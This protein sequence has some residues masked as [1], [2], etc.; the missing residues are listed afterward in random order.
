MRRGSEGEYGAAPE[1]KGGRKLE[2]LEKTLRAAASFG[3]NSHVRKLE[4]EPDGNR[5]T[6]SLVG[7]GRSSS[8]TSAAPRGTSAA[9]TE[10]R[11]TP[12]VC[13]LLLFASLRIGHLTFRVPQ[14]LTSRRDSNGR[15]AAR[16]TSAS[17]TEH[18]DRS[19][20]VALLYTSP[21][22]RITGQA[23]ECQFL[24]NGRAA[25]GNPAVLRSPRFNRLRRNQYLDG[26]MRPEKLDRRMSK[27]I[28]LMTMLILPK[29]E[30]HTISMQIDLKQVFQKCSFYREQPVLPDANY[31]AARWRTAWP[32]RRLSEKIWTALSIE[33]LRDDEGDRDKYGAAAE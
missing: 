11:G 7:S 32:G 26:D 28:R 25:L 1:C 24:A 17:P 14:L 20:T 4:G 21:L 31:R 8:C 30:E 27:V 23:A 22:Q 16:P 6:S 18:V 15:L 13:S 19:E 33:V 10:E 12:D 3:T 5:P 2:N 29:A 9:S